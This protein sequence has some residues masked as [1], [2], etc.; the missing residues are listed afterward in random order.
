M[1]ASE[2][3]S[4]SVFCFPFFYISIYLGLVLVRSWWCGWSTFNRTNLLSFP[5]FPI[6]LLT[7]LFQICLHKQFNI[8]SFWAYKT[9]KREEKKH[10]NCLYLQQL[11]KSIIKNREKNVVKNEFEFR[12]FF[13]LVAIYVYISLITR[14]A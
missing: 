1:H 9:G 5:F 14:E 3:I 6:F 12:L 13:F 8:K 4:I 2:I 11:H 7:V 10:K